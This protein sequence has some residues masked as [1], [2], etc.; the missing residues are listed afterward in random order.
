MKRAMVGILAMVL[1]VAFAPPAMAIS[2]YSADLKSS[3]STDC[4]NV[5]V[6]NGGTLIALIDLGAK[7]TNCGSAAPLAVCSVL[8]GT[9]TYVGVQL[10]DDNPADGRIGILEGTKVGAFGTGEAF[11]F[12]EFRSGVTV[13]TECTTGAVEF[14]S[15][16]PRP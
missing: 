11:D 14:T 10:V 8:G 15:G 7:N 13:S 5:V 12:L 6:T 1:L 3:S 16:Q 4:G 2:P 9:S